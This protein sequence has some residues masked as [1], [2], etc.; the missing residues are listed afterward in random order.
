MEERREFTTYVEKQLTG[1][2]LEN[3]TLLWKQ[4][5]ERFFTGLLFPIMSEDALV[6]D[7]EDYTNDPDANEV[8]QIQSIGKTQRY[9]PP[10][11][12]GFSLFISGNDIKLRVYHKA[13]SF[14]KNKDTGRKIQS[15]KKTLLADDGKEIELRP[16]SK[17]R[18][19]VLSN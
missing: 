1:F 18:H 9:M 12:V 3:D 2:K 11:S 14:K 13:S 16:N 19:I 4:P 10:S 15:W 17:K 7:L 6:E 8:T 5:L